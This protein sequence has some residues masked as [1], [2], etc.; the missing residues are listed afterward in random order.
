MRSSGAWMWRSWATGRGGQAG[1]D[2]IGALLSLDVLFYR[3]GGLKYLLRHSAETVSGGESA[4]APLPFFG[5]NVQ[6]STAGKKEGRDG[7]IWGDDEK[8]PW[9]DDD[10]L[11]GG[12][13]LISFYLFIPPSPS[14]RPFYFALC[15]PA[16]R[17]GWFSRGWG[18]G[19]GGRE[20]PGHV[21]RQPKDGASRHPEKVYRGGEGHERGGRPEGRGQLRQRLYGGSQSQSTP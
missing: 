9:T 2:T 10:S 5:G 15:A 20:A 19:V 13:K 6:R 11:G 21:R 16:A 12:L 17:G 18:W 7:T 14:P 1:Q 4:R 3:P 8:V